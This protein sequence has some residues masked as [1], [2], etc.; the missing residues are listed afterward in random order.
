MVQFKSSEVLIEQLKASPEQVCVFIDC[1]LIDYHKALEL[2]TD[3]QRLRIA[4]LIPDTILLLEHPPVLTLGIRKDKNRLLIEKSILEAQGVQIVQIQR[5]GGVTAHNPGQL[6]VY[7]IIKIPARRI[8]VVPY[9]RFLESL[10]I[11][12]ADHFGIEAHRR[13]RL[14]GVW[15]GELKL[16]SVGVQIIKG[17]TLHGIAM[18]I[19][20]DLDLFK[21][22]I[23]CGLEG[24][25][26]TSMS[27]LSKEDMNNMQSNKEFVVDQ[28][29]RFLSENPVIRS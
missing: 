15:V 26:M 9:I 22:I 25:E 14:P 2:Q 3:L 1:G 17:V 11:T 27:S 23:P 28:C 20:N 4:D 12:L 8:R 13:N 5:G 10:C 16:A 6:V 21:S 7:P 24:V 29:I 19:T 18:N